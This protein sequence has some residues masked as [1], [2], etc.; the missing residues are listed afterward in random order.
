MA[1]ELVVNEPRPGDFN[2]AVMELG[3]MVC[4]PKAPKCGQC[5]LKSTC[6]AK[7]EVEGTNKGVFCKDDCS[8]CETPRD[9]TK[10]VPL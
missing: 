7:H 2:Q 5:P 4:T 3:A 9:R 10:T 1:R 8:I 6:W